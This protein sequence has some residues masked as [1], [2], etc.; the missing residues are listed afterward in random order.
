VD[1]FIDPY[2]IIFSFFN[3][4]LLLLFLCFQIINTIY[5]LV[6]ILLHFKLM[7]I[8][9]KCQ[10]F[11]NSSSSLPIFHNQKHSYPEMLT[12]C[13]CNWSFQIV[14]QGRRTF[15]ELTLLCRFLFVCSPSTTIHE[16]YATCDD[17]FLRRS[18][19][20]LVESEYVPIWIAKTGRVIEA[21]KNEFDPKSLSVELAKLFMGLKENDCKAPCRTTMVKSLKDSESDFTS[22]QTIGMSMVVLAFGKRYYN[23]NAMHLIFTFHYKEYIKYFANFQIQFQICNTNHLIH[24]SK[25]KETYRHLPTYYNTITHLGSK[26]PLPLLTSLIL[27]SFY[28][29]LEPIWDFGWGL[30]PCSFWSWLLDFLTVDHNFCMHV[31]LHYLDLIT[32]WI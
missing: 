27:F 19:T 25:D 12:I 6:A 16:G 32:V 11:Y 30:V 13:V 5:Q 8:E 10:V 23:V 4:L 1:I 17:T 15:I 2:F 3:I 22:N 26:S 7:R 24:N 21:K 20:R 9:L 14:D 31:F 29:C 18:L 28:L